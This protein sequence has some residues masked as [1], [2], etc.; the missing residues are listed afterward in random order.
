MWGSL[1]LFLPHHTAFCYMINLGFD[2]H[3][4]YYRKRRKPPGLSSL[5]MDE[6][7]KL[8]SQWKFLDEKL[9][10]YIHGPD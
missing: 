9:D 4:M 3:Y 5:G 10:Y 8:P 1:F 6:T 7:E 2:V